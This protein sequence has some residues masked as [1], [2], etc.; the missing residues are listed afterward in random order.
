MQSRIA[1]ILKL[2]YQPAALTWSDEKPSGAIEFK[3]DR[4]GCVMFSLA[5]VVKGKTAVFSRQ[6]YGCWGGGVGLGFGNKY[7]D[8]PGGEEC[9]YNFLSSGNKNSE[10]GRAVGEK[11]REAGLGEFGDD[12]MEGER[13]I[14]TPDHVRSFVESLP[15]TEVPAKYVVL[16]PLQEIQEETDNVQVVTFLV[17]ADQL[18]ALVVLANYGRHSF[19]NVS[20]PFVAGCQAI[21][22]LP[23]AE[24]LKE[25]PRAV[26]GLMDPSARKHLRRMLDRNLMSFSMPLA[27]FREME[28]N[29]DDS[30]L[31]RNTWQAIT[32]D[33]KEKK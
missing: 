25:E 13:Y 4:W 12:F 10:Q 26:V 11:I 9:F 16:K 24:A 6:T 5:S 3:A 1:S 33:W 17:D 7:Q 14:K 32:G 21:A 29:V 19:E 27:L 8:F 18:C 23:Y 30:F 20:I 31:F 22:L 28:N 15:I 2:K